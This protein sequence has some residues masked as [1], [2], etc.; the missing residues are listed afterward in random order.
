MNITRNKQRKLLLHL[1]YQGLEIDMCKFDIASKIVLLR[2]MGM[3][4]QRSKLLGDMNHREIAGLE[5]ERAVVADLL[6]E[7]P[8]AINPGSFIP[9]SQRFVCVT[10]FYEFAT[11]LLKQ[12]DVKVLEFKCRRLRHRTLPDVITIDD[13]KTASLDRQLREYTGDG[14]GYSS[15]HNE[16]EPDA[17]RP[18]G[19]L[20]HKKTG[21]KF[22]V[23]EGTRN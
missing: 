11:K 22:F 9:E 3:P 23:P 20:V 1:E 5:I 15:F 19:I 13:L 16:N 4:E 10:S 18:A 2:D 17:L 14:F 7:R 12:S 6:Y 8:S 21:T